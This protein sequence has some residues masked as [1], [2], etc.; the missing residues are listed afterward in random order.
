MA[1][2]LLPTVFRPDHSHFQTQLLGWPTAADLKGQRPLGGPRAWHNPVPDSL[3]SHGFPGPG[4]VLCG[5]YTYSL[6][7]PLLQ[8]RVLPSSAQCCM[9]M[10]SHFSRASV[11]ALL[12]AS[13]SQLPA[14]Q[15]HDIPCVRCPA[16]LG[17]NQV[18][19]W[20]CHHPPWCRPSYREQ[21]C[22]VSHRAVE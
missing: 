17:S 12:L 3:S 22:L 5:L 7:Q 1:A 6:S 11:V 8:S 13:R 21:G 14:I 18:T 15:A 2:R 16:C 4:H 10:P 20:P 19:P 9:P